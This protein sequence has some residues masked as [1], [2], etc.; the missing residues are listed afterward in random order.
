MLQFFKQYSPPGRK[1]PHKKRTVENQVFDF[2]S[3]RC[4]GLFRVSQSV[5]L[6]DCATGS[7]K[8]SNDVN[9]PLQKRAMENCG[10]CLLN[11]SLTRVNQS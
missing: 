10:I 9:R 3:V 6:L 7:R 11:G 5:A 4:S 1:W 8:L 2:G